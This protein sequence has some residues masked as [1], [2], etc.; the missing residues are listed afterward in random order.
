MKK[1]I[2]MSIFSLV[3]LAYAGD[4]TIELN[5][6]INNV[7]TCVFYKNTQDTDGESIIYKLS[8][9]CSEDIVNTIALKNDNDIY[10]GSSKSDVI[11]F[12]IIGKDKK[13]INFSEFF[14]VTY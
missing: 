3:K 6:D 12:K 11:Y 7:S 2:L 4:E 1:I 9:I 8:F 13:H 14:I 5:S 10:I